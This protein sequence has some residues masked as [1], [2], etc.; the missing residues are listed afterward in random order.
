MGLDHNNTSKNKTYIPVHKIHKQVVSDHTTFYRN[1]L[2]LV[3]DK[4]NKKI[5]T[6][7]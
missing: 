4:E 6:I 7:Y 2:N 3:V 5:P 1:R